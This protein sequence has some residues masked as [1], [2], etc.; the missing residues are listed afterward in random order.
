MTNKQ[1]HTLTALQ[2]GRKTSDIN[3]GV[4]NG[5]FPHPLLLS[6]GVPPCSCG[7]KQGT[8]IGVAHDTSL[9]SLVGAVPEGT[10]TSRDT[11]QDAS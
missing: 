2:R 11:S 6:R 7:H 10:V 4:I 9:L 1:A 3:E 8:F 5:K